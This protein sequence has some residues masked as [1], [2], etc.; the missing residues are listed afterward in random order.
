MTGRSKRGF[1]IIEFMIVVA[2]G[3]I[4][5]TIAIPYFIGFYGRSQQAEAKAS[6]GSVFKAQKAFFADRDTY[7]DNLAAIGWV[8]EGDSR[9]II[10][11]TSDGVPGASGIN[12]TAELATITAVS[13]TYLIAPGGLPLT[14]MDLPTAPVAPDAFTIGAAGNIDGDPTLDQWTLNDANA[15]VAV[16]DDISN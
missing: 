13:T 15:M 11:F 7:S 1:T 16:Q 4:L 10:G 6:L 12:D 2:I 8:P 3:S 14:E 9:Y 5:I